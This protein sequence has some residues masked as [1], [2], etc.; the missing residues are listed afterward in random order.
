ML[1][2]QQIGG[3]DGVAT[4]TCVSAV[5]DVLHACSEWG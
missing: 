5:F 3:S 4:G 2:V 1:N